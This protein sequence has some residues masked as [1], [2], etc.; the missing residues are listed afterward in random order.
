MRLLI[1]FTDNQEGLPVMVQG[2]LVLGPLTG[3]P[4]EISRPMP[5]R[6]WVGPK[7]PPERR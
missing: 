6:V 7:G 4:M 2:E 1:W 3:E 5:K